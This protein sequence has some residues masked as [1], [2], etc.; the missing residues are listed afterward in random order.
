MVQPFSNNTLLQY[1]HSR[2]PLA[3]NVQ[4]KEQFAQEG[5]QGAQNLNLALLYQM[6]PQFMPQPWP[7]QNVAQPPPR[8]SIQRV[9]DFNK[10]RPGEYQLLQERI[11]V[12]EGLCAHGFNA[13]EICLLPNVTLPQKFKVPDLPKYK[14]LSYPCSHITMYCRKMASYI[15]NDAL[16]IHCFQG[17]LSGASLVWYMNLEPGKIRTWKYLSEAFLNQYYRTLN[18]DHLFFLFFS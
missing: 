1:T 16:L 10:P 7:T 18:F 9:P 15:E 12:I 8:V 3:P 13:R 5:T 14:G 6:Y 4:P 11:C 2:A 17:S